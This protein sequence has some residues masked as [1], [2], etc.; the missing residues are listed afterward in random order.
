MTEQPNTV[1]LKDYQ[2]SN[3]FIKR[4]EL[5]FELAAADTQ[6][7]SNL[8]IEQNS[9][10]A[11]ID[12]C[13]TLNGE[14]LQ[15]VSIAIDDQQLTEQDYFLTKDKLIIKN[16][17]RAAKLTI[18]NRINPQANTS[19]SG[20]YQSNN[21][22]CTQCEA[23]GFRRITYYL[24]RPDVM[25]EFIT[26]IVA[27]KQNYP[28]LLSNGNPIDSGELADGKHF[29]TWH[30]PFKKPAYLFALVAGAL[31]E[32]VDS[33]TTMSGRQVAIKFYVEANNQD[34]IDF[35]I[36]S[37]KRAMSW[38]EQRFRR[39]YDLDIY[40]VVA[41]ND[42]NMGAMENKGLNIF[43]SKYVLGTTDTATD[44]DFEHIEAVIGHEYFHNWTGNRITLR[45]WF[46]LSLKEGLTVFREQSFSADQ[47]QAIIKRIEQIE[48]LRARQFPEDAGPMAHPVRPESY[49]EINNFYTMTVYEKGSEVIRIMHTLLGE[50]AFQKGMDHYFVTFDGQAVTCE[51]LVE[52]MATANNIDLQQFMLWYKQSGTPLVSITERYDESTNSYF[53]KL[54]QTTPATPGQRQKQPLLIPLRMALLKPNGQHF[55][56]NQQNNTEIVLKLTEHEQEFKFANITEKPVLSINRGFSAPIIVNHP[57]AQDNLQFLLQH[58][59]DPIN[60]WEAAQTLMTIAI[61]QAMQDP[62]LSLPLSFVQKLTDGL[63]A[64]LQADDLELSFKAKL[65]HLPGFAY[66][67]ELQ[68]PCDPVMLYNC[69]QKLQQQIAS[70]LQDLFA[71]LLQ[72]LPT[73]AQYAYQAEQIG[74]RALRAECLRY[75]QYLEQPNYQLAADHYYAANNMTD[76]LAALSA[77]LHGNYQQAQSLLADFYQRYKNQPVVL[78]HWLSLQAEQSDPQAFKKIKS[79]LEHPAFNWHNPNCVYSLLVTFANKNIVHF[80]NEDGSGYQFIINAIMHLDKQ[81]PQV[82][83]RLL[84]CCLKFKQL[85]STYAKQ[86]RAE[87]ARLAQGKLSSDCYEM[88]SKALSG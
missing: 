20:L 25:A 7:H 18:V 4:T 19:L 80:H 52:S 72:Q 38:D 43:N 59:S 49:I 16:F 61:Q 77:A 12:N 67:L 75:L 27:D 56:L 35:A 68:T 76:R 34:K 46:Q 22:F 3:Y 84:Q 21:L 58:E 9:D 62:A 5:R 86:L 41:V 83:A 33:F 74:T 30:D 39:E 66:L 64:C 79:L 71:D 48:L 51:D 6:V 28:Y 45:N 23:E 11:T 14:D 85:S 73:T 81:N 47:G 24:D 87:L 32:V 31:V 29:V 42:F 60:R 69:C 2:P 44:K 78:N 15:L 53:L 65:L 63:Q 57:A 26:T 1:Y 8:F 37:L 50:T 70:N 10:I 54:Q 88:V 17:P 82:A 13:L 40:M 55:S 36:E